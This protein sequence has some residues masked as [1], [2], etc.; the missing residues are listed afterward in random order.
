[1]KERGLPII[2]ILMMLITPIA[3][4]FDHCAGMDMSES[5]NFSITP[6]TD[7][8]I[9]LDHQKMLKESQNNQ[10]MNMDCH[11]SSNCTVHICGGGYSIT[12]SAPTVNAV[13]SFYYSN[14]EYTPPYN[15]FLSS[16][17]RP[18]ISIL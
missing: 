11:S 12:S 9:P 3:S 8:T 18:P 13:T 7:D 5:Q 16:E 10:A 1:M 4:A 2:L 14:F 17:L 15:T 6:T